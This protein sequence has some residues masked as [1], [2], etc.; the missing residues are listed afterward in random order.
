MQA[1]QA[2][3]AEVEALHEVVDRDHALHFCIGIHSGHAVLGMVGGADRIE[4]AALGEAPDVGKFLQENA[5]P[6][7]IIISAETYELV[8][9]QV[10]C[11]TNFQRENPK[12]ASSISTRSTAFSLETLLTMGQI[13]HRFKAAMMPSLVARSTRPLSFI[14]AGRHTA[15]HPRRIGRRAGGAIPRLIER[16]LW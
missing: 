9:D 10:L 14:T 12:P 1:A 15:T 13:V 4:F 7:E 6:G 5:E 8:K 2:I 11:R 16:A 3:L